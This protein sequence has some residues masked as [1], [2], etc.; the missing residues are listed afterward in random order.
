MANGFG[1]GEGISCPGDLSARLPEE[2]DPSA[3]FPLQAL[4]ANHVCRHPGPPDAPV[5]GP[6]QSDGSPNLD[7]SARLG[8]GL[9]PLCCEAACYLFQG[10]CCL[11]TQ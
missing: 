1:R 5:C 4:D 11:H 9:R 6:H 3:V 10:S 7:V 8:L 2:V